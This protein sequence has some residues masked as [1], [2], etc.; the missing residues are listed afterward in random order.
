VARFVIG[1]NKDGTGL[2]HRSVHPVSREKINFAFRVLK[3]R[4]SWR[5]N[6]A[7]GARGAPTFEGIS[8][9]HKFV[10][11][12]EYIH[13]YLKAAQVIHFKECEFN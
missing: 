11:I 8:R 7:G 9:R 4:Q 13:T 1:R 5:V 10:N 3:L 2:V 6:Y 12:Y